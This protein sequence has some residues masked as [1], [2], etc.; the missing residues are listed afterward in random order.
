MPAEAALSTYMPDLEDPSATGTQM[1]PVF[2]VSGQKLEVGHQGRSIAASNWPT[3]SRPAVESLVR[4]GARES[5]VGRA[6][7][8]R[9]LRTGR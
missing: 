3:G 5:H 8:A 9:L 2:F 4:P 6:C 7:R 1:T